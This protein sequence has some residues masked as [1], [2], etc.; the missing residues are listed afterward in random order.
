MATTADL[1]GLIIQTQA[2]CL[3]LRVTSQSFA[4]GANPFRQIPATCDRPGSEKAS[5]EGTDRPGRI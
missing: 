2:P 5:R 4:R 1:T 3:V